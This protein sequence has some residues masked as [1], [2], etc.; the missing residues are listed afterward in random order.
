MVCCITVAPLL[1][2]LLCLEQAVSSRWTIT[3]MQVGEIQW[4]HKLNHCL[5]ISVLVAPR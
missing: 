1:V 3:D 2:I 5:Q 4:L